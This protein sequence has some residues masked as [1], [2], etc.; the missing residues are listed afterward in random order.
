LCSALFAVIT[1]ITRFGLEGKA[2]VQKLDM[3]EGVA[4][5]ELGLATAPEF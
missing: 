2:I 3:G 5:A 4:D 1:W